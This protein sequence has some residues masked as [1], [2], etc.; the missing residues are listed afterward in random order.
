MQFMFDI[1]ILSFHPVFPSSPSILLHCISVQNI[2]SNNVSLSAN[3]TEGMETR[4][5]KSNLDLLLFQTI[6][7]RKLFPLKCHSSRKKQF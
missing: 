6:P 4:N 1:R 3:A 2:N 7:G 5:E